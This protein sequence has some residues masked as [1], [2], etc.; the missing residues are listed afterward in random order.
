MNWAGGVMQ[1]SGVTTIDVSATLRLSGTNQQSLIRNLEN[2]GTT[3]WEA[4]QFYL[5]NGAIF[6][7]NGTFLDQHSN[8]QGLSGGIEGCIFNNY[9][10]YNINGAGHSNIQ[11]LF[12]NYLNGSIQGTGKL[13]ILWYGFTNEGIVSPGDSVGTLT[14][15]TEYPTATTSSLNIEIGGSPSSEQYDKLEIIGTA[16]LDGA[17]NIS[18]VN[19]FVPALGDTFNVLTYSSYTGDFS[20]INGLNTGTGISFDTVFT[21]TALL[22]VTIATSDVEENFNSVPEEFALA[23]NYPNPFNPTTTIK[24]QIPELSFV[25]LKIYDVLGDE[26]A[27]LISEEKSIGSYEVEFNA[28]SLTSGVYFYQLKAGS[29]VETKKIVLMK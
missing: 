13:R 11:L 16:T 8:P 1:E 24:Y 14:L 4:G 10:V 27:T 19:K 6:N 9:G 12:N 28:A 18:L 2:N 3:I 25:T 15:E 7:N 26:I 17:L 5:G 21:S 23:Q 22:L 29:F 20:T